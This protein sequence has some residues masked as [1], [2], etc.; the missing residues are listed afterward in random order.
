MDVE[1]HACNEPCRFAS[2]ELLMASRG[3]LVRTLFAGGRRLRR[4][5]VATMPQ[6]WRMRNQWSRVLFF[7]WRR[8]YAVRRGVNERLE[9][10]SLFRRVATAVAWPALR[11]VLVVVGLGLAERLLSEIGRAHV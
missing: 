6:Y 4:Y 3:A 9:S 2:S 8:I 1:S 11:A 5:A 7:T 10:T